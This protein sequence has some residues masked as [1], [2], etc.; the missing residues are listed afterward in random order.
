MDFSIE[1][2]V[3]D[4]LKGAPKWS[5]A[6]DLNGKVTLEQLGEYNQQTTIE[7]AAEVLKEEQAKGF[8]KNPVNVK[9]FGKIEFFSRQDVSKVL[10][11]TYEAIM[12]R[13]VVGATGYFL[14]HNVVTFNG[15]LIAKSAAQLEAWIT[16]NSAKINESSVF[17][18]V[19]VA[20]Y[21]SRLESKGYTRNRRGGGRKTK[22]RKTGNLISMPN[23]VYW[24]ASRA[25]RRSF[26]A[27]AS[28]IK[29]EFLPGTSF[30]PGVIPLDTFRRNYIRTN[31]PYVYPTIVINFSKQG[32]TG[33]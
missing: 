3:T 10:I 26:K 32:T 23:G 12:K 7:I 6:G 1:I 8:D 24:L 27:Q 31:K 5:L 33:F 21:A 11:G 20:P 15:N 28:F 25:A 18:F 9:P 14:T 22:S 30:F 4:N 16:I 2:S 29:F 17:R 13:S 19:N